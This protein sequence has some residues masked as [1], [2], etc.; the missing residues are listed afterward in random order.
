MVLLLLLWNEQ[1]IKIV[2]NSYIFNG[3]YFDVVIELVVCNSC[4]Y[5]GCFICCGNNNCML[6]CLI[7]V[8]YNVIIYVEKVEFVGVVICL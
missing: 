8:M 1:C 3:S 7:G 5:D 2:L 6:I 4:F